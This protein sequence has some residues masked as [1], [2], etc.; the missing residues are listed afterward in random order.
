MRQ[1]TCCAREPQDYTT[2][3]LER[4]SASSGGRDF[5]LERPRLKFYGG[6]W[7]KCCKTMRSQTMSH[8]GESED[9]VQ[10]SSM[11]THSVPTLE[12]VVVELE[13]S[14]G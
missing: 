14:V 11:G 9:R 6:I 7:V 2:S 1:R 5:G 10:V 13:D 8:A 4:P 3:V 12:S